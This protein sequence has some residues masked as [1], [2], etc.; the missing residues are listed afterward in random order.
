MDQSARQSVDLRARY[1][2]QRAGTPRG[3]LR[4]IETIK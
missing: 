2:N 1:R 4:A 3:E